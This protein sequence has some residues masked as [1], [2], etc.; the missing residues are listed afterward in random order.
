MEL[1]RCQCCL[2]T[3]DHR[4]VKTGHPVRNP[5]FST[6]II[7]TGS[8]CIPYKCYQIDLIPS[9][10]LENRHNLNPGTAS[11]IPFHMLNSDQDLCGASDTDTSQ[12]A[13]ASF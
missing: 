2:V 3:Y 7:V 13:K 9:S 5:P 4:S 8:Q 12:V 10:L 1:L 6:S 11:Y